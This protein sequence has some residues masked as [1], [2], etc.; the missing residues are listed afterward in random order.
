MNL[1]QNEFRSLV[2]RAAVGVDLPA[3][4]ADDVADGA[5]WLMRRGLDGAEAALAGLSPL[6]G[7]TAPQT[8]EA[9]AARVAASAMDRLLAGD[10]D[11]IVLGA[12]D[13]PLLAVGVAFS[14]AEAAS[15]GVEII[16]GAGEAAVDLRQPPQTGVRLTLRRAARAEADLDDGRALR[17]IVSAEA[18]ARL[19]RLAGLALVPATAASRMLGAGAGLQDAD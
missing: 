6:A 15:V 16:A 14:R 10:A 12:L 3:G 9:S 11:E 19:Q 8:S 4:L 2:K 13:A 1:S 17:F 5:A 18:H 7:T